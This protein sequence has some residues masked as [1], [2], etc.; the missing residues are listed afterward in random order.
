MMALGM[1]VLG[2][3]TSLSWGRCGGALYG[4]EQRWANWHW[5]AMHGGGDSKLSETANPSVEAKE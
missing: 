1:T 3:W 2:S 5:Q 4:V